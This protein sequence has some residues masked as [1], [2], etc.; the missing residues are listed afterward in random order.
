[1]Y[2]QWSST[3]ILDDSSSGTAA[4]TDPNVSPNDVSGETVINSILVV[5]LDGDGAN[6]L[7]VTL[8]RNGLSGITNDALVWLQNTQTPR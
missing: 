6:D 8:D 5:D 1:V 7:V 4:T 2:D 3:L